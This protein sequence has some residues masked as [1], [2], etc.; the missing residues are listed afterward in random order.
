MS[1]LFAIQGDRKQQELKFLLKK[2]V[3]L[4]REIFSH[5]NQLLRYSLKVLQRL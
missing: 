1:T 4:E 2:Y 3:M 5:I